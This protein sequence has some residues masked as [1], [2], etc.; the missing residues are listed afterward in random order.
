MTASVRCS[1]RKNS[2]KRILVSRSQVSYS[3][4][5]LPFSSC[6]RTSNG[7]FLWEWRQRIAKR[8]LQIPGPKGSARCSLPF[9][10]VQT[11]RSLRVIWR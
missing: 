2:C 7:S 10:D 4:I 9:H 1:T 5:V 8:T 3:R 11:D 6:M